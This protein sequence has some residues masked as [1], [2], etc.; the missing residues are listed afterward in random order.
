MMS[1]IELLNG[2]ANNL[3]S[4]DKNIVARGSIYRAGHEIGCWNVRTGSRWSACLTNTHDW[5]QSN[6]KEDLKRAIATK[7]ESQPLPNFS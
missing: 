3:V 2:C 7:A 6:S 5:L 1:D 4:N